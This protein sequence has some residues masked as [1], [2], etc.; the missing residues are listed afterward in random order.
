MRSETNPEQCAQAL[1]DF[2][3]NIYW[4]EHLTEAQAKRNLERG[5]IRINTNHET[6]SHGLLVTDNGYF[7]TAKHC[8]E[9]FKEG[10]VHLD[11]GTSLH[12]E[13]VC[14]TSKTDD[15]ALCRAELYG[16]SRARRY[17]FADSKRLDNFYG[18]PR[19]PIV[20]LTRYKEAV[21]LRGGWM[22]RHADAPLKRPEH[23]NP[24]NFFLAKTDVRQ[25]DSGSPMVT[26]DGRLIGFTCAIVPGTG[27]TIGLKLFRALDLVSWYA[28]R[29]RRR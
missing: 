10:Y 18:A 14:A 22:L 9:D 12:L 11:D 17:R 8:V 2:V 1:E 3:Q 19:A 29:L 27:I 23:W 21:D 25:G 26:I 24:E 15:I 6:L 5:L 20:V 16:Q 13:G 4:G 7:L 28:Q